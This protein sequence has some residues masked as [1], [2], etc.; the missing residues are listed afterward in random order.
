MLV[1]CTCCIC[2]LVSSGCTTVDSPSKGPSGT[3]AFV[4][5]MEMSLTQKVLENH[6]ISKLTHCYPLMKLLQSQ[7][8]QSTVTKISINIYQAVWTP[9]EG[10]VLQLQCEPLN[11]KDRFAVAVCLD[12]DIVGRV[13][14]PA[15]LALMFSP[16]LARECNTIIATITD[17]RVNRGAGLALEVPCCYTLTGPKCFLH[18]ACKGTSDPFKLACLLFVTFL[19]LLL[20]YWFFVSVHRENLVCMFAIG[21]FKASV[22]R[23]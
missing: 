21:N 15:N 6:I 8:H 2:I 5:C 20:I 7:K 16:F 14:I 11:P 18:A 4:L 13:R 23:Y 3:I 10:Q 1:V 22:G 17:A 12:G 9:F 19:V